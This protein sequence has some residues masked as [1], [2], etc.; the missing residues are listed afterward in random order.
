MAATVLGGALVFLV[1]GSLAY[2]VTLSG[3]RVLYIAPLAV[4]DEVALGLLFIGG[5]FVAALG[6]GLAVAVDGLSGA[7]LG[8]GAAAATAA[9]LAMTTAPT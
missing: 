2:G 7:V 1:I 6:A 8:V 9:G 4:E 3:W 5:A